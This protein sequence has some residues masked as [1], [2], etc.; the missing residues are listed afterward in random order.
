MNG[1]VV[2]GGLGG[3]AGI[4]VPEGTVQ[5]YETA[6]AADAVL[7]L[8]HGRAGDL[9]QAEDML[10]ALNPSYLELHPC[11]Q[12]SVLSAEKVGRLAGMLV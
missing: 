10:K 4:Q 8:A 9:A 12:P 11:G 5:R 7:M 1:A 3:L 2:V 6:I